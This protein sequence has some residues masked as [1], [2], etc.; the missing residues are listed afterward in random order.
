MYN[1]TSRNLSDTV[2]TIFHAD[3][4]VFFCFNVHGEKFNWIKCIKSLFGEYVLFPL[5]YDK[6]FQEFFSFYKSRFILFYFICVALNMGKFSLLFVIYYRVLQFVIHYHLCLF[7]IA[8]L[9]YITYIRKITW[10]NS[11]NVILIYATYDAIMAK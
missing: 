7:T 2:D 6:M 9:T 1:K 11:I 8:S 10:T 5:F 3:T 4:T